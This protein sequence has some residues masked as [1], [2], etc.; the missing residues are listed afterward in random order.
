MA[1]MFG[2]IK[3][4]SFSSSASV[5]TLQYQ[6][7]YLVDVGAGK[8]WTPLPNSTAWSRGKLHPCRKCFRVPHSP[9][10]SLHTVGHHKPSR[11]L[12]HLHRVH[13]RQTSPEL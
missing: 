2:G 13:I 10:I 3:F 1:R 8:A 4:S 12:C 7:E 9:A 11:P 5:K 6:K